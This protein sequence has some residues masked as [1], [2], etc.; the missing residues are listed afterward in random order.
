MNVTK[1]PK[2]SIKKLS[3]GQTMVR[4]TA[5]I[6]GRPIVS[7]YVHNSPGDALSG[8]KSRFDKTVRNRY[9]LSSRD[10][11]DSIIGSAT[12]EDDTARA[13]EEATGQP[14]NQDLDPDRQE[15]LGALS[16]TITGDNLTSDEAADLERERVKAE[17]KAETE[18]GVMIKGQPKNHVP[19]QEVQNT[20][21]L[22]DGYGDRQLKEPHPKYF[23]RKGD[24]IYENSNNARI[25]LGRDFRPSNDLLYSRNSTDRTLN[26]GY[27][28]HMGAG[29]IDIVVGLMAPF[30][31]ENIGKDYSK[32]AADDD[33][34]SPIIRDIVVAPSF[35]TS[36]PPEVQN[37]KL[38]NGTHPGMVMDAARIYISQM[39]N[40]DE[41]FKISQDLFS[42]TAEDPKL[43]RYDRKAV[44]PT[45]GIVLKA[46]KVRIH[47]RQEIKIV[48]GGPS[49][50]YNSQGNRIK[51]N[52]GIHLIAENGEDR[53][54]RRLHQQPLVLG[55]NLI[56]CLEAICTLLSEC[57]GQLDAS[58]ESQLRFNMI[59]ANQFHLVAPG[60]PSMTDPMSQMQGVATGI[61]KIKERFM[62]FFQ[63]INNFSHRI[64]YFNPM[65]ERYILSRYNTTN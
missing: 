43:N 44:V 2:Y 16:E 60:A 26:S 46:D 8:A 18:A 5:E 65:S 25:V 17:N 34:D 35:N 14:L 51:Q 61:E 19:Y 40:V 12:R 37:T 28:D 20:K 3:N 52:N 56:Q 41:N 63:D 55:D 42:E 47:S 10:N 11:V 31:L 21:L 30:P 38:Y 62:A 33:A 1:E 32:E 29:A 53:D 22:Y 57:V 49:E 45:S 13:F 36:F 9:D 6:D 50:K 58:V 59:V 54:G 4:Y 7:E 15:L 24:K 48:T 23:E 64:G 27:S 39:T